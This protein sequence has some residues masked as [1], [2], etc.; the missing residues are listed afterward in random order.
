MQPSGKSG[1]SSVWFGMASKNVLHYT[2]IFVGYNI[3]VVEWVSVCV[4]VD[5]FS[6]FQYLCTFY[7]LWSVVALPTDLSRTQPFT[8]VM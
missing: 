1:K 4:A 6:P 8:R 3:I 7:I 2:I 5:W